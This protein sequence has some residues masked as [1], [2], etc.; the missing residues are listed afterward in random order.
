MKITRLSI[1]A[2]LLLVACLSHPLSAAESTPPAGERL[3]PERLDLT[4]IKVYAAKDGEGLFRAYVVKWKDQEVIVSDSLVRTN[5]K[6]GDTIPV[7]A[8]NHP[9]PRGQESHR[10]LA[11]T[12][13]PPPPTGR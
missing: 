4:V 5:Y 7:L 13:I 8:M 3:P 1:L 6:E 9:F 10:L 2:G 12:V 11:F